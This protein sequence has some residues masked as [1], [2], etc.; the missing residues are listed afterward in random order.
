MF[1]NPSD[2]YV[3]ANADVL[4]QKDA[5]TK[6]RTPAW[7]EVRNNTVDVGIQVSGCSYA[8][9]FATKELDGLPARTTLSIDTE[10]Y[11]GDYR[12]VDVSPLDL[13]HSQATLER[14]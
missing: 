3:D 2:F 11:S 9:T 5:D 14:L 7:F 10:N 13:D 6:L 8:I 12:V 1:D 4:W